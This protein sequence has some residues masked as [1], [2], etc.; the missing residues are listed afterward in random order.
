MGGADELTPSVLARQVCTWMTCTS[1]THTH[2]HT[3]TLAQRVK[4]ASRQADV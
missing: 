3:H 4:Q 1:H 2:T